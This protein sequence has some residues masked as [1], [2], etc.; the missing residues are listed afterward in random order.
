MKGELKTILKFVVLILLIGCVIVPNVE[1]WNM[2]ALGHTDGFH[3][4]FS[5]LNFA[6]ECGF[7]YFFSKKYLFK[8]ED[9]LD[10]Q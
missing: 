5:I 8:K 9:K 2:A 3:V 7:V 1:I 10:K 4:F 6:V